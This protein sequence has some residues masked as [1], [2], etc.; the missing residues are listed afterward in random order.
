VRL[1]GDRTPKRIFANP[2]YA[3][4]F[5]ARLSPDGSLIAYTSEESGTMEVWL[6]P[7]PGLD[8]KIPVSSGG[9]FRSA[10]SADS[11]TLYY[12]SQDRLYAADVAKGPDLLVS[13]PRLILEHLPEARYDASPDG[14]RFILAQPP[15]ASIP[16][17][18]INVV[19][20][21]AREAG[22]DRP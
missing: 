6:Q 4:R 19:L 13:A 15:G 20:N 2:A 9:G 22:L 14:T 7:F 18:R 3:N 10:W 8:R 5:G 17:T 12:R 16:Q 21:W 1:E 11:K